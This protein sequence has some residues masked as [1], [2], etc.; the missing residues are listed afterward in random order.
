[1]KIQP[2]ILRHERIIMVIIIL[3]D[4][5]SWISTVALPK[6][7][8][9]LG[10]I[11]GF[12]LGQKDEC[13]KSSS[14]SSSIDRTNAEEKKE[15]KDDDDAL[16]A[17]GYMRRRSMIINR[18]IFERQ[19]KEIAL[20]DGFGFDRHSNVTNQVESRRARER[21]EKM[22]NRFRLRGRKEACAKWDV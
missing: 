20:N 2:D 6:I 12:V 16:R 7:S 5:V 18:N 9:W 3:H 17:Q 22:M 8:D 4:D 15:E 13:I 19:N 21:D 1:M 10:R 11:I 14:W